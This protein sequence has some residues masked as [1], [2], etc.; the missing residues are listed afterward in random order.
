MS[1]A[2]TSASRL[3][4]DGY[5]LCAANPIATTDQRDLEARAMRIVAMPAVVQ[6]RQ[7]AE[8]RWRTIV[9]Q[10]M[11]CE[12]LSRFDELMTE[13]AFNYVLLAVNG[14]ANYPRSLGLLFAPPHD[15]FGLRVSGSRGGGGDGPDTHY[16]FIPIDFGAHYELTGQRLEPAAA[17]VSY[18]LTGNSAFTMTLNTL[19][20]RDVLFDGNGRFTIHLGPEPHEGRKNY[21]QTKPHSRYLFIRDARADWRQIPA[22]RRVRRMEPPTMPPLSD[23]QVAES[24]A[25]A[26][27]E[28]VPMRY[29]WL[30]MFAGLKPN[31]VTLPDS[32][33]AVGGNMRA[34]YIF[35]RLELADDE[36]F[37]ITIGTGGAA[38]HDIVL[39][40]YWFRTIDYPNRTSSMNNTQGLPNADGSFTYVVATRDPGVHNWLDPDGLHEQNLV[41][42][43]QG[44]AQHSGGGQPSASGK[45]VRFT[46]LSD[47]LPAETTYVT[48]TERRRQLDER[49]ASYLLRYSGG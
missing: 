26:M 37:V 45:M 23:E 48:R 35:A 39:H 41:V 40:D 6:G 28:D 4:P 9:G 3:D 46:D 12:R 33:A 13:Y 16:S 5:F 44:L 19:E 17:D 7:Q 11:N 22:A 8:S 36:A 14:D 43:W 31:Q 21:I 34:R 20:G 27:V 2:S 32:G 24:A 1:V 18:T 38:F 42:R 30:R 25:Q 29:W 47:V 49:L 10:D 15:W